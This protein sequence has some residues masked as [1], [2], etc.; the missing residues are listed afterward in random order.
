M[1]YELSMLQRFGFAVQ[2]VGDTELTLTN[3][4]LTLQIK[5]HGIKTVL[6]FVT[7]QRQSSVNGTIF[8]ISI[9]FEPK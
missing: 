9:Y 2:N 6:Q 8:P 7:I 3:N 4:V 1:K 5:A